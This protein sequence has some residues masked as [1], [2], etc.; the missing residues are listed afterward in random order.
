MN[1]DDQSRS[2]ITIIDEDRS[3]WM[4][5]EDDRLRSLMKMINYDHESQSLMKTIN[6]IHRFHQFI[7][8][9]ELRSSITFIDFINSCQ[10][11]VFVDDCSQ[12]RIGTIAHSKTNSNIQLAS[13]SMIDDSDL[14]LRSF[15]NVLHLSNCSFIDIPCIHCE[16]SEFETMKLAYHSNY[17]VEILE[18]KFI[19]SYHL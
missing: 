3:C 7:S 9:H 5:N 10:I 14:L 6:H 16:R 19:S 8:N 1:E 17:H 11:I 18:S 15:E 2:S 13:M 12:I 4:M